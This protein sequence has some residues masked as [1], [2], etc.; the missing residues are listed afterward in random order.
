MERHSYDRVAELKAAYDPENL[1][2]MNLNIAAPQPT[3]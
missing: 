1:F 2:R 3:A